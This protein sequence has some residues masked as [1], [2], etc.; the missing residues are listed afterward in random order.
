MAITTIGTAPIGARSMHQDRSMGP[1]V[2]AVFLA[3][4]V[5]ALAW[6]LWAGQSRLASSQAQGRLNGAL[7]EL[8]YTVTTAQSS[9]R[10][11]VLT[12]TNAFL[13]PYRQASDA[14]P[15]A[16]DA[17]TQTLA[18]ARVDGEEVEVVSDLAQQQMTFVQS[19]VE[20]RS[21]TGF[22]AASALVSSGVGRQVSLGRSAP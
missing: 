4:V 9:M 12:G 10:G 18:L 7:A 20:T 5:A 6:T 14:F 22:E 11:F 13:D 19:V 16:L 3:L 15:A 1:V 17:V 8:L 2:A 21:Q